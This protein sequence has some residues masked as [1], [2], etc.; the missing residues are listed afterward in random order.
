MPIGT[1]R[2]LLNRTPLVNMSGLTWN[3]LESLLGKY[4]LIVQAMSETFWS[5][6]GIDP[7]PFSQVIYRCSTDA[8]SPGHSSS[9]RTIRET[10]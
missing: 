7:W 10:H 3:R 9:Y 2:D 5:L 6:A 8:L 4:G 1:G